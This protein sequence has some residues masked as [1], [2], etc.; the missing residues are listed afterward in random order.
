LQLTFREPPRALTPADGLGYVAEAAAAFA[1][2]VE[3][4]FLALLASGGH[5]SLLLCRGLGDY[6]VLGGTLD[7]ALGEA[8]DKVPLL[9]LSLPLPLSCPALPCPCPALSCPVQDL[10]SRHVT[11]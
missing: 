1:P 9:P 7:D 11:T 8:F 10:M 3:Y 4:P 5:T 6:A 2:K